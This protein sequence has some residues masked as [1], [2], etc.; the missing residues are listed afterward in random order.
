MEQSTVKW[1]DAKKG[2][3]FINHPDGGDDVFVHYSQIQ[4]DDDFKTLHTG[5]SVRFELNDGPKGLHAVSVH[6]ESDAAEHDDA[7][8]VPEDSVSGDGE[9]ASPPASSSVSIPH[10][11]STPAESAL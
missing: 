6:P 3:G 11:A 8:P 7:P 5:Q 10:D 4:S 2:Y 1:F 9:A